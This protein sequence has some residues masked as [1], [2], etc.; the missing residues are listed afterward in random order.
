MKYK[1]G[2]KG[3]MIHFDYG[4]WSK[5]LAKQIKKNIKK[6]ADFEF[7]Q[8]IQEKGLNYN[9][10]PTHPLN[11]FKNIK[12]E[13]AE[14]NKVYQGSTGNIKTLEDLNENLNKELEP[15]LNEWN[16][17]KAGKTLLIE[18]KVMAVR[19]IGAGLRFFTSHFSGSSWILVKLNLIDAESGDVIA[20]PL[21]FR[22]G[23]KGRVADKNIA[24]NMALDIKEYLVSNYENPVG[25]GRFP[26]PSLLK[27]VKETNQAN[28]DADN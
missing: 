2:K 22:E 10:K 20:S 17:D 24:K 1:H 26:Y 21:L 18:P 6:G 8:I 14:L 11:Q 28:N 19:F 4:M 7:D 3:S 13:P 16:S 25:G 27:K 9:Q 23:G 5:V 12:L 15:F